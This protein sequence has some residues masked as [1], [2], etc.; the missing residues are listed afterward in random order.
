[1]LV[2]SRTPRR[3]EVAATRGSHRGHA[4]TA[5]AGCND[6]GGSS[7]RSSGRT[8]IPAGVQLMMAPAHCVDS[9]ADANEALA[10]YPRAGRRNEEEKKGVR[11]A[12]QTSGSAEDGELDTPLWKHQNANLGGREGL[13]LR[14]EALDQRTASLTLDETVTVFLS[15]GCYAQLPIGSGY[16]FGIVRPI[17]GCTGTRRRYEGIAMVW[18][19]LR[20]L[21]FLITLC[22]R[23]CLTAAHLVGSRA[24]HPLSHPAFAPASAP[25]LTSRAHL[26]SS[27]ENFAP[28]QLTWRECSLLDSHTLL[29][30]ASHLATC[31]AHLELLRHHKRLSL[32]LGLAPCKQIKAPEKGASVVHL[33]ASRIGSSSH[34]NPAE[35]WPASAA[36]WLMLACHR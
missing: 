1:M 5:D 36:V 18:L 30:P 10:P 31:I 21:L 16:L 20:W 34:R 7:D 3:A 27:S 19:R 11:S 22:T 29:P 12:D 13:K 35:S 24:A 25:W 23:G 14:L 2:T 9:R 17:H 32:R 33:A 8:Q 15:L 28:P 4:H 26:Q 6:D